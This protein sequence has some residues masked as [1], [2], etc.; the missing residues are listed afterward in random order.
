MSSVAEVQS[1]PELG[2]LWVHSCIGAG[3]PSTEE[4]GE[5][6]LGSYP[7]LL[8]HHIPDLSTNV[9]TYHETLPRVYA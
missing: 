8:G 6:L 9:G 7:S 1:V 3:T 5:T 2:R 4:A